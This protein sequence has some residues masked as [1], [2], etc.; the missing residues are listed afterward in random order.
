MEGKKI[1]R[2]ERILSVY[3]LFT[4]CKEVSYKEVTDQMPSV[5]SKT[6]ARDIQLLRD[7]GVLQTKYSRKTN[8]FIPLNAGEVTE[9]RL[10]EEKG[11]R[12][13]MEKIRRLC[14]LMNE[15]IEELDGF[16]DERPLHMEL[17]EKLF[18]EVSK[19]TRQRDLSTLDNIG[20]SVRRSERDFEDENAEDG[21]VWKLV[22]CFEAPQTYELNTFNER[23]W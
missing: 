16:C 18:P 7:A 17:H 20:Y 21:W 11:Q 10:P 22:Y 9:P 14:I 12:T 1:P 19:R 23:E 8:A 15:M 3:H 5:S 4:H 13:F 6:V 2:T